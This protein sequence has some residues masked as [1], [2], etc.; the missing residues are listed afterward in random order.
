[1]KIV[2]CVQQTLR[3][4]VPPLITFWLHHA[5]CVLGVTEPDGTPLVTRSGIRGSRTSFSC[6]SAQHRQAYSH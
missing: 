4:H 6:T 3:R 2:S 1:V 5:L